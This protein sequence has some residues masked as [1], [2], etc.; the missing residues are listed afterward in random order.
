MV[1]S[2]GIRTVE[3]VLAALDTEFAQARRPARIEA[4]PCCL[5][6]DKIEVL[7]DR[8]RKMLSV[9]DIRQYATVVMLGAGSAVDL[10]YF[11]PRILELC[12]TGE[13]DFPD[14][15]MVYDRLR[16]ADWTSW[17]ESGVLVELMDALWAEVLSDYPDACEPSV[18]LC[19]F[20]AA[21]GSVAPYLASWSRLETSAAVHS[22]RDFL[23]DHVVLRRGAL[24][25][26]NTF[27]DVDGV[28]H[29]EVVR[30]LNGGEARR[31]VARALARP[32]D[33]RDRL[34]SLAESRDLLGA[35]A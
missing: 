33:D 19:A 8:P 12:H 35:G 24:V 30:W 6:S 31:A 4:C 22:L 18:L 17:P 20:G 23:T 21:A 26:N 15:E 11:A 1:G 27:W 32:T 25:P 7:L 9:G 13:M 5:R 10:R 14:I 3:E 28:G 29:R 34:R 16:L 2:A